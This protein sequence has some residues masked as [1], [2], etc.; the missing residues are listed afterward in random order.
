M[1]RLSAILIVAFPVL[2]LTMANRPAPKWQ[3]FARRPLKSVVSCTTTIFARLGT[4][5]QNWGEQPEGGVVRVFMSSKQSK[6]GPVI[7][8]YFEGDRQFTSIWMDAT[9][10]R[11]ANAAWRRI[12][13]RCGVS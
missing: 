3:A 6:R 2:A 7:T 12:R 9:D 5:R 1:M 11:L 4:V 10:T 8:A 13:S